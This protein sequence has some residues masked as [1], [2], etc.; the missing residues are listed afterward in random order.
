MSG[1][2][3]ASS[4]RWRSRR[5]PRSVARISRSSRIAGISKG[6]EILACQN[7]G[8]MPF[9]PK[10]QTSGSKAEGRFGKPDFAYAAEDDTYRCP[11]G[12]RLTS[13][14]ASV[15]DGMTLHV[16]WTPPARTARSKPSARPAL[17]GVSSGGNMRGTRHN[18]GAA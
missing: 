6:E 15:E 17:C 7:A 1:M 3:E 2:T 13:R 8:M 14:F 4:R 10:P 11:A 18:A 16:Y 12:E 5:N 9:V